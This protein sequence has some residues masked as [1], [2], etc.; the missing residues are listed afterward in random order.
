MGIACFSAR[1]SSGRWPRTLALAW[2]ACCESCSLRSANK[3]SCWW[4][5]ALRMLLLQ[6]VPHPVVATAPG[7][8]GRRLHSTRSCCAG[9]KR[10]PRRVRLSTSLRAAVDLSW[11]PARGRSVSSVLA[12]PWPPC[13]PPCPR[14]RSSGIARRLLARPPST[15]R[16]SSRSCTAPNTTS[17]RA[18]RRVT[19]MRLHCKALQRER[20]RN[21]LAKICGVAAVRGIR[22]VA[23]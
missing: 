15:W 13:R 6:L 8:C 3:A 11:P 7:C 9:R 12:V 23:Q 17:S 5:C 1:S 2:C 4:A 19:N 16:A 14:V 20:R 22:D 18:E 10:G 21:Y